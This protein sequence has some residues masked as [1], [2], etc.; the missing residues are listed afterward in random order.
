M[1][2]SGVWEL[3]Y[4]LWAIVLLLAVW[5]NQLW[6]SPLQEKSEAAF[7]GRL[8]G[9][10]VMDVRS[11]K[12]IA[13]VRSD[14]SAQE[15]HPP[16]SIFKL[17]T[18]FAALQENVAENDSVFQCN[19][20]VKIG[21]SRLN[22]TLPNG[23]GRIAFPGAIARSCNVSFYELGRRL[24]STRILKYARM[25][26]LS[27]KVKGYSRAQAFGTLPE[28]VNG[29]IDSARLAIG[30]ARGFEITL[31]EAAEMARRLCATYSPLANSERARKNLRYVRE[32]MRLAVLKGTCKNAA[33]DGIDVA[34]KTGSPEAGANGDQRS[35]W[36]V[37]FA[38]YDKPEIVVAVFINRGH[39]YDT[40]APIASKIFKAYFEDKRK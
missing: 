26:G 11:G 21:Q 36:F 9:A 3:R 35:A 20:G 33:V 38:P 30:Q 37:G 13:I 5:G 19:G 10:V 7:N 8:G 15:L 4:Y 17:V 39:G 29:P 34:G 28:S 18:A 24:G 31:L 22:C 2:V 32:G 27:E 40:A 6:G 1:L 25:F 16:G 14:V 23:H 12:V